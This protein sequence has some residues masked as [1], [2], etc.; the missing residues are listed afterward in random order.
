VATERERERER[1]HL[2]AYILFT[3]P[4]FHLDTSELNAVA[5]QN[6]AREGATKKRKD[7]PTINHKQ[8]TVST[9]QKQE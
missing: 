1:V 2:L 7:Q 8:G 6:T 9:T 3:A 4:V 5:I